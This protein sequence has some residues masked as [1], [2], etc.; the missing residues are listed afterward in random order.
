M[1]EP[2]NPAPPH[3][4]LAGPAEAPPTPA[5]PGRKLGFWQHLA[6][7]VFWFAINLHWGA[8]LLLIIPSQAERMAPFLHMKKGDISG[9]TIGLGALVGAL[10][11]PIIG[12]LS[13]RCTSRMGRRRPFV[14][15]GTLINVVALGLFYLA[16]VQKSFIGYVLAY[17]L[18]NF[19]NNVATAAFSGI[20]PDLVPRS[21]RGYASGMMAVMQQVGTIGGFVVGGALLPRYDGLATLLIAL[22]LA[23]VSAVTV[24]YTREVPI[25][26]AEPFRWSELK[27]CFWVSPREYPDFAWVWVQRALFT[28]GW[29]MIQSTLFFFVGDVIGVRPANATF[30]ILGAIVLVGAIPTGL[31]GGSISDRVGRKPI[32][33]AAGMA[34][35]ITGVAFATL[36]T[37]PP[38]M[39]LP[40]LYVLG[41]LWGFGYGAYISVDW[42]LGTDVLP[43]P[44]AHGKDMGVWHLSMTLP[45]SLAAPIAAALL[46]PFALADESYRASGYSLVYV[47]AS[48]L[49]ALCAV[50]VYRVKKVR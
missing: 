8:Y 31:V 32:I 9:W 12:L 18:V 36:G 1:A 34:M 43:N 3:Q 14:I 44:D 33:F 37:V 6:I 47:I 7:S 23:V 24:I 42:A 22:V 38:G 46:S 29:N 11:P 16:F 26:G 48:A 4:D 49:L 2:R 21:E 17:L 10:V 20:I 27:D 15:T 30:S 35:A 41:I 5:A 25:S 50:L 28:L 45:M 39:R 13:D 40:I 19:G